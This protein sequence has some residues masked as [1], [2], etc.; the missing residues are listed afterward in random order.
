MRIWIACLSLCA[1]T[2][3]STAQTNLAAA[4]RPLS[5]QEC[6]AIALKHNF[7]VKISRFAPQIERFELSA[8]YGAYD[9]VF[10]TSGEH[11]YSLSSGGV[12]PEGRTFS[13]TETDSDT[14]T[15]GLSGLLPWG[16]FYNL[17]GSIT[18]QTGTRP[19]T[20]I[21]RSSFTLNTNVIF[22]P[23]GL[24][25][26]EFLI[27]TNFSTRTVRSPFET[28]SGRAGV[29]SL[30]QPLLR[31]FW[32]DA[33]R[34][35]IS[36][37]K[38]QLRSSEITFRNDV[39]TTIRN[40]EIAYFNLISADEN[41]RVQEK[42]LEL[43]E[44]LLT[45][46]RKRVEVGALAPLDE[47]QAEAEAAGSRAAL[48]ATRALRDSQERVLKDLLSDDYTNSWA[49]VKIL[50]TD[51]LLA[52][53]QQHDLQESW[54][55]GLA[56]NP[57][58]QVEVARIT[59]DSTE[60]SVRYRRN[61]LYPNLDVLGSVGYSG[62]GDE[63]SHALHQIRER[64]NPSWSFGAQFSVPL[65]RTAERN[66]L[67]SAKATRDVSVLQLQQLEQRTLI[68]IENDIANARSSFERVE[69]TR[70]ARLYRESALEA[71]Q[72]KLENGK[73]TSFIV[74]QMQRDLTAAS[75]DEITALADYNRYLAELAYDEGASLE[76]HQID[77]SIR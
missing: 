64:E 3:L 77:L 73:S 10:T 9:P 30:Q 40:V 41:V 72:K 14:I 20:T 17:G 71:E 76:R 19:S 44:R 35:S 42:A 67:R 22:G 13:G 58:Y 39:M 4:T 28:T 2:L 57:R 32:I 43:A 54:R 62:T 24:P 27:S 26:G 33:T 21:D 48:L 12:D 63:Y 75:Y 31:D 23:G 51:K 74:L 47:R 59:V 61:Q 37:Q 5:L 68:Q 53:P 38:N 7:D 70:Q 18:D 66:R 16:T 50:T 52:V 8:L 60:Q 55:R 1:T 15:A 29:L 65:S 11:N 69:A 25:T 56:R 49:A 6:I 46:N 45:E 34:L 36:L